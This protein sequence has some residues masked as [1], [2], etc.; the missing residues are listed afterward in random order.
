ML[1]DTHVW[2]WLVAD[3]PRRLGPRARRRLAAATGAKAPYVSVASAFEIAA[4]HTAGRLQLTQT[5][6]RWILESTTRS[7]LRM[8]HIDRDVMV[9]AGLIPASALP[10][11]LDR[12]LVATAR[13]HALPLVTADTAIL[14]YARRTRLVEVVDA[15][16]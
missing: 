13:E 4:L 8:L 5:A 14:D 1:L 7:G 11:P 10:D 6:E 16:A 2:V 12:I 3:M 15:T 9:D